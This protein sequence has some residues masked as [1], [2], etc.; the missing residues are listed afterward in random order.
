MLKRLVL[1]SAILATLATAV[2]AWTQRY[3]IVNNTHDSY[4]YIDAVTVAEPSGSETATFPPVGPQ[5]SGHFNLGE[6]PTCLVSVTISQKYGPQI[7]APNLFNAC[8][9]STITVTILPTGQW[10]FTYN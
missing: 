9:Q 4:F 6:L 2:L 5:Q 3:T 10:G 7:R 8:S 1:T